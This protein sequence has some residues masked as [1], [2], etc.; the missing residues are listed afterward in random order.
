MQMLKSRPVLTKV[1]T[2]AVITTIGDL[3][4]QFLIEK[5]ES[6]DSTR[7]AAVSTFGVAVAYI[8]GH[9]WLGV[10]ERAIGPGMGLKNSITKTLL[11]QGI[12]APAE[13]SSFMAWT[14]FA[15]GHQHSLQSKLQEDFLKTLWASYLFWGPVCLVE[16]MFVP[17]PLR[18]LYISTTS[19]IWDTFLSYASHNS[20]TPE[21]VPQVQFL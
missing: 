17:Y 1:A 14:H 15:E 4:A 16:F 9:L 20:L 6:V 13:T 11:D 7:L 12:F 5:H 8:E 3:C 2:G 18:V 19:V 10:L 21:S